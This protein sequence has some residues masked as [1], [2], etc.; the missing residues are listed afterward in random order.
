MGRARGKKVNVYIYAVA[1]AASA[2]IAFAGTWLFDLRVRGHSLA[3]AFTNPERE[4]DRPYTGGAVIFLALGTIPFI[5]ALL[6]AD[7]ERS[8]R[9][10]GDDLFAFYAA[11]ALVFVLGVYD[12]LRVADFKIKLAGQVMAAVVVVAAGFRMDS[13]GLPWDEHV[14]VGIAGHVLAVLWIVGIT[15]A[16]N[17]IDGKDGVAAGVA[18]LAGATITV[19]AVKADIWFTGIAAATLTAGALGFLPHNFPPSRKF[20]GDSGAMLLGFG[21]ATLSLRASATVDNTVFL[22]IPMLALG[23][24][25][26]DTA[27]ALVRRAIDHRH[28]LK[29]DE[30]HI[31]HRLEERVGLGP[32][33]ILLLLYGLAALFSGGALLIRFVGGPATQGLVFG[34]FALVIT[35][36]LARLGYFGSMWDS[37]HTKRLRRAIATR[38][39]GPTRLPD[40]PAANGHD[41]TRAI[42]R[43]SELEPRCEP[44]LAGEERSA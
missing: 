26:V 25:I 19:V 14:E 11:M 24:P 10:M 12:D 31:H 39:E 34:A 15:N 7:V 16:V 23:F 8:M 44:A 22:S 18:A 38:R 4:R 30:D 40:E 42:E 27:L 9:A 2:V 13:I 28:P 5:A 20:L 3:G 6:S 29:G 37:H 33:G 32:R 36:V 17:L 41:A 43:L 35:F 21:L 1:F